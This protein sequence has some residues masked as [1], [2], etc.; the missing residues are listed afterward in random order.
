[1]RQTFHQEANHRR[2]HLMLNQGAPNI[3][4]SMQ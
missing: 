4:C 2:T 3:A 1:M